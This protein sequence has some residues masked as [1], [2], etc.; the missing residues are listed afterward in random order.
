[1]FF[2]F[3]LPISFYIS[4]RIKNI[5][6]C[7]DLDIKINAQYSC[8]FPKFGKYSNLILRYAGKIFNNFVCKSFT[9][10]N[11]IVRHSSAHNVGM[12]ETI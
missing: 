10:F 2:L 11:N 6:Y 7:F 8:T 12:N 9:L 1:M 4:P 3:F 5:K